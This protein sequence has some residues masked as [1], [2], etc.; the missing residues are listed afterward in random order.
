V[1]HKETGVAKIFLDRIEPAFGQGP[2]F[3]TKL[4]DE[5]VRLQYFSLLLVKV[6]VD[7]INVK[8]VYWEKYVRC[9]SLNQVTAEVFLLVA[10]FT[11]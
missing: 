10:F 1:G 8:K 11:F 3:F 5:L 4:L 9:P 7:L 6:L 2:V